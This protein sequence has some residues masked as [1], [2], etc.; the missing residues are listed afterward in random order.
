MDDLKQQL[1]DFVKCEL[2]KT[3]STALTKNS[4]H[5]YRNRD[6]DIL[7]LAERE[8]EASEMTNTIV[9]LLSEEAV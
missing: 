7:T 6:M 3:I 1:I 9:F 5:P 4:P 8:Q 2:E